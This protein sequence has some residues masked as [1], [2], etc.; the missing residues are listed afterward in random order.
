MYVAY[1]H[2][3]THTYNSPNNIRRMYERKKSLFTSTI[4]NFFRMESQTNTSKMKSP[5]GLS[6]GDVLLLSFCQIK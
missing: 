6:R 2:T 5:A 1:S 4:D 3:H